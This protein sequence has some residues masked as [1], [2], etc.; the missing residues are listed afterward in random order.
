MASNESGAVT[1]ARFGATHLDAFTS[2]LQTCESAGGPQ[3]AEG[4]VNVRSSRA[5]VEEVDD[6]R[7]SN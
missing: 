7:V 6:E 3:V 2:E 1:N 5:C 4:F